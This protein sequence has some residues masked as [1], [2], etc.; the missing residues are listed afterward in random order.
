MTE[1][2]LKGQEF[3]NFIAKNEKRLK[4]NLKKNITYDPDLFD[5]IFQD[6]IIKAYNTIVSNN[7]DI[8]DYEQYFFTAS[9]FNYILKQNSEREKTKNRINI[10]DYF[11]KNDIEDIPYEENETTVTINKIKEIISDEF[12][13]EYSEL[14]FDY[15]LLKVQGGMSYTKYSNLTG[16]PISKISEIVSKVKG[17]LKNNNEI[18]KLS[19]GL[20]L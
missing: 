2:E 15:M 16:V 10:D 20:D 6:T 14:Y 13:E 9:K 4:K 8:K 11:Q 18:K 1:A 3:L 12:N 17:Y 19:N 5:D 7:R